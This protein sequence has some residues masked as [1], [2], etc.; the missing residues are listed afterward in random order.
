[1]FS[2][3]TQSGARPVRH[4]QFAPTAEQQAAIDG[5]VSFARGGS[6]GNFAALL[7]SAGTGK[8]FITRL[9]RQVLTAAG[10]SVGLA[11]P[12]HKAC[13]VLA[14]ACGVKK[15]ETTTFASLL[16]LREKKV[17]DQVEFVRDWRRKPRIDEYDIWL[18]D[19]ASMLEPQM[20]EMIQKEA[21]LWDRF[22]FIGDPAQ[23]PPVNYGK[24]SPA[25]RADPRF[26]LSTV[27]RH[28]GAV[29][30]AA[31]AIRQTTG[32]TWRTCFRQSVIGDGSA[33]HVY[34]DKRLWQRSILDFA[35]EHHSDPDAFRVL[36]FRRMEVAKINT[37]IRWHV[38][39]R[40][41]APFLSGE[42][43]VTIEA[44]KD[45]ADP[46]GFP[47]FGTSRE[48]VIQEAQP[49]ELLH[50]TCTDSTP[51]RCWRLVV[52]AEGPGELPRAITV[53]DPEH[54]GKLALA[55]ELLAA[56]AKEHPGGQGA[57]DPYW[58]LRDGFAQVQPAWA[59]TVHKSQG[60]QFQ[61][62]FISPDLD[63]A[64]GAKSMRRHLWYTALTRAQRAVHV[65]ADQGEVR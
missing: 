10:F 23:L 62:V 28:D 1:M 12:T 19:E 52:L 63:T 4:Q 6:G 42:R 49:I 13:Q 14:D 25:L 26:E 20:L 35:A 55:L 2:P 5:L 16:A 27:M 40:D 36:C 8:T 48:L 56:E 31:T 41:A 11:A 9:V 44:I 39:G 47:L 65:V 64:P 57:W 3:I 33:I 34:D 7:G 30:D 61:H 21:D 53:I 45:P 15:D 29:L 46:D 17:K 24:A 60:S 50:P 18:C 54:E 51:Y 22:V 43:L 58:E 59:M 32:N 37:A 38:F